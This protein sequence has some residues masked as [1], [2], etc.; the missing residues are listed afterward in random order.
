MG[1]TQ[2]LIFDDILLTLDQHCPFW[3]SVLTLVLLYGHLSQS[4]CKLYCW[5][6]G[7]LHAIFNIKAK[8]VLPIFAYS[9]LPA[10]L[11]LALT[12][13]FAV[14]MSVHW[15]CNFS[16]LFNFVQFS[17]VQSLSR[18]Q[19]FVIPWTA[20][21]KASLSITNPTPTFVQGIFISQYQNWSIH[22]KEYK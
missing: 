22:F 5:G 13:L 11:I 10:S 18:V 15:T 1:I 4:Q 7:L 21:C 19:L 17:S 20:A 12:L 3:H 6:K 14:R 9:L 8:R 2:R 16:P